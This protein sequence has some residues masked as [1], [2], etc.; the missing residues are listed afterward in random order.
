MFKA[1]HV[2][3]LY[4]PPPPSKEKRKTDIKNK[5]HCKASLSI[6]CIS[7]FISEKKMK[8]PLKLVEIWSQLKSSSTNDH[9]NMLEETGGS[10]NI[11]PYRYAWCAGPGT[12][13]YKSTCKNKYSQKKVVAGGDKDMALG[14][15]WNFSCCPDQSC[16]FIKLL[17]KTI[18]FKKIRDSLV[19]EHAAVVT[20]AVGLA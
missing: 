9:S 4:N 13:I 7:N 8:S 6:K 10:R 20:S 1:P 12:L 2:F 3:S 18:Y 5:H 14:F 17:W 11:W 19:F 16:L 15:L